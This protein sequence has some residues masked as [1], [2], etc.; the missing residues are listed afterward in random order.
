MEFI[1]ITEQP[2]LYD[3]LDK[4]SVKEIL[5][6]I[7]TEDHKLSLIHI[8]VKNTIFAMNVRCLRPILFYV[9]CMY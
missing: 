6:D 9:S 4:K 3:D 2:S 8:Y 1:K 7:N 5:E